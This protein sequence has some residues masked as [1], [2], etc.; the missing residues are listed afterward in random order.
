ME[1]CRQIKANPDTASLQVLH[2]STTAGAEPLRAMALESGADAYLVDP[3]SPEVLVGTIRALLRQWQRQDDLRVA[4]HDLTLAL[5]EHERSERELRQRTEALARSNN[6]LK[7]FAYAV[8]HDLQEPLRM[9]GSYSQLLALKHGTSDPENKQFL[10]EILQGVGRMQ[11]L[12]SDL[13]EYSTMAHQ[14]SKPQHS[15]NLNALVAE[16]VCNLQPTIRESGANLDLNELP[17]IPVDERKMVRLFQNLIGNA[18]KYRSAERPAQVKISVALGTGA[19]VFCV[20]DNGIGFDM[21]EADRIFGVFQR[22]HSRQ[23]YPGTGIGLAIC[24]RIVDGHSGKIWA[25][26]EEGKGSK[27]F[28]TIPT[29]AEEPLQQNSNV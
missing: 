22:L 13:L 6:E 20:Q 24:K 26:S 4:Q 9:I 16:A 12:I 17:S 28:F 1:V 7:D 14:E 3:V 11:V 23:E 2:V 5:K 27:F 19:W 10:G 15:A 8:S 21:S 18:I 25:E 29:S